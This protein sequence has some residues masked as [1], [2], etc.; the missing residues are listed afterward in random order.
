MTKLLLCLRA[1]PH[2]FLVP[3]HFGVALGCFGCRLEQMILA[4]AP[5]NGEVFYARCGGMQGSHPH[6]SRL[7]PWHLHR[8][9][10]HSFL[11]LLCPHPTPF[12]GPSSC[13]TQLPFSNLC[14]FTY[15]SILPCEFGS[16]FLKEGTS[17]TSR[18]L[19]RSHTKAWRDGN[20]PAETYP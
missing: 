3:D 9:S 11:Y 2:S 7:A 16:G 14:V 13:F 12:Y 19:N 17:D 8:N 6:P 5:V 15:Q 20:S 18:K 1:C 4:L 10:G